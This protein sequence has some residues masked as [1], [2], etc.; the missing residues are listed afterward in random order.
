MIVDLCAL[1]RKLAE[2]LEEDV[3]DSSEVNPYLLNEVLRPMLGGKDLCY[4][5]IDFT[6]FNA[7]DL[8]IVADYCDVREAVISKMDNVVGKMANAAPHACN[9][10]VYC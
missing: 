5:D 9:K 2:A 1:R 4:G 6:R 10:R 7:D 8:Q 3:I